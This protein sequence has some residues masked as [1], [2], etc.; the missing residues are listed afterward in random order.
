[1]EARLVKLWDRNNLTPHSS[2]KTIN[3]LYITEHQI[4]SVKVSTFSLTYTSGALFF[5]PTS[6]SALPYL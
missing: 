6:F 2:G 3:L 1:M 4:I 5:F